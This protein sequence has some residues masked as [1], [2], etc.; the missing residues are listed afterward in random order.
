MKKEN[1]K[2]RSRHLKEVHTI[3]RNDAAIAC[4]DHPPGPFRNFCIED[5]MSTGDLDV[6]Q[7]AFYD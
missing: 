4:A 2:S 7:D 1:A 6:G 3:S 5:V